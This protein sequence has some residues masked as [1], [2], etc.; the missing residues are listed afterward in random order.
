M[1]KC[2]AALRLQLHHVTTLIEFLLWFFLM[3]KS[4]YSDM[5]YAFILNYRSWFTW[6]F[7]S[8][9]WQLSSYSCSKDFSLWKKVRKWVGWVFKKNPGKYLIHEAG[10]SKKSC[11]NFGS[12]GRTENV[13]KKWM[14]LDWMILTQNMWKQEE[15]KRF[16]QQR[17]KIK[18]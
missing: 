4:Q 11:P 18:C 7:H 3:L 15:I 16:D 6:T 17:S 14:I 10:M 8:F 13:L 1:Y 2:I 9:S 5:F 12:S